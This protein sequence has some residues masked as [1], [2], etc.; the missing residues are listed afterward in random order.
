MIKIPKNYNE[1]KKWI[2]PIFTIMIILPII[3]IYFAINMRKNSLPELF[4]AP[5]FSLID[6]NGIQFSSEE[7]A[8]KY[9]AV[10][11]F[12]TQCRSVCPMQ[13]SKLKAFKDQ[14]PNIDLE[15][16]SITVDPQHDNPEKLKEYTKEMSIDE[17]RWSF[18]TGEK[19]EIRNIVVNGFKSGM[20]EVQSDDLFDIA[21]ANYLLLI[22]KNNFVRAVVRFDEQNFEEKLF[23]LQQNIFN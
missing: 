2:K 6:Q 12:F 17:E 19:D 22:D 14:Y 11:F 4:E 18:L 21:H 1:A 10:N 8:G 20:D 23:T 13:M 7:M 5:S 3:L 9:W 15:L 16:I